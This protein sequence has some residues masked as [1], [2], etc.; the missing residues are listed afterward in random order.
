ME[1]GIREDVRAGQQLLPEV[2][3]CSRTTR[4]GGGMRKAAPG[5]CSLD[6]LRGWPCTNERMQRYHQMHAAECASVT[7]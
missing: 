1:E 7:H 3:G 6:S 2:H 5:L 4:R